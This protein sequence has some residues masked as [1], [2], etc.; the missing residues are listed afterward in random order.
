MSAEG[1]VSDTEAVS[2][3][4][5]ASSL[6]RY[7]V[8][9]A[10]V[11][12]LEIGYAFLAPPYSYP[13]ELSHMQAVVHYRDFGALPDPY[14]ATEKVQQD[15]HP[16][17]LY[18][19]AALALA[20]TDDATRDA[21]RDA[22]GGTA[23]TA[24]SSQLRVPGPWERS[25]DLNKNRRASTRAESR[26]VRDGQLLV[27][28]GISILHWLLAGFAMLSLADY[29][30]PRTRRFAFAI[31]LFFT[32][33][34]QAAWAGASLTPDTPLVAF[35]ALAFLGLVKASNGIGRA[36]GLG[37][38]TGVAL[39][40]ALLSKSAAICLGP[41]AVFAL[42]LRARSRGRAETLRF[43][44]AIALPVVVL[45][46]WWYVRNLWLY[47]DAFQ[48]HAQ[49]ETYT[50]SM[51]REPLSWVSFE[52]MLWDTFRTFFGFH[53]R[54]T[55]LPRPIFFV[56]AGFAG[57]AV[58][59]LVLLL[60]RSIR[61]DVQRGQVRAVLLSIVAVVVMT[62]LAIVGNMTI[63]SAQ[64]RY[65]HPVLPAFLVLAGCGFRVA[66]RA[67]G[68]GRWVYGAVLLWSIGG[69]WLFGECVV[70]REAVL[71]SRAAGAGGVLFYEDCGS[72]GLH[73][74]EVQ[75]FDAPDQGMLG[76]VLPQRSVSGHPQAVVYRFE[77]APLIAARDAAR[78]NG[79]VSA[80]L[81]IR[82]LYFAPD[83]RTPYVAEELGR[84][85]Y[86]T[87]RLLANDRVVHEAIEVTAQ[88][89]EF[90]WP[91]DDAALTEKSLELRFER[92]A[93]VA[94]SVAEL[95]I[96]SSWLELTRGRDGVELRNR[97]PRRVH[98]ELLVE[99][100]QGIASRRAW[101]EPGA[102]ISDPALSDLI[103]ERNEASIQLL[104]LEHAPW[105]LREAEAHIDRQHARWF[106]A[107]DASGGYFVRGDSGVLARLPFAPRPPGASILLRERTTESRE[108]WVLREI[109]AN[110]D[111]F[112][113]R[114]GSLE[115]SSLDYAMLVGGWRVP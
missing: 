102:S 112:E 54:L 67:R 19:L 64:G 60:R 14:D 59:G 96:E 37:I 77:T 2:G 44:L 1:A 21:T 36:R 24:P 62:S 63:P 6:F 71:R 80:A 97:G 10:F 35:C 17:Y 115:T 42:L 30:F 113:F 23:E 18:G 22:T 69:L 4:R 95:W 41:V 8:F 56:L 16:P 110:G 55:L 91:I 27:L 73:P 33:I 74:H 75:G 78:A 61:S 43:T 12:L 28:R 89:K 90:F 82:V 72:P 99:S 45:A 13:D 9:F 66:T 5:R 39:T 81:Q 51:R 106:G 7:V 26:P 34:P 38:W 101:L 86:A 111:V 58:C 93:G 20:A 98:A 68:D 103:G 3:A 40:M 85:V 15:K 92:V 49:V 100:E 83:P 84:F 29:V 50:H 52:A 70:A 94:A 87:Q 79:S 46:A 109:D 57:V 107:L 47:G 48:M 76:R 53:T 114:A 65:L 25:W 32:S 108:T 31:A 11:L 88:P 105:S 104:A